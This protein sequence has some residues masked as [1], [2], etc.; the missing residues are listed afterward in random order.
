MNA[1]AY[2]GIGVYAFVNP[3]TGEVLRVDGTWLVDLT[4]LSDDDLRDREFIARLAR[5]HGRRLDMHKVE[6]E[7][8][9]G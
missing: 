1:N 8:S 2:R 6:F 7:V 5:R 3:D 9:N 4:G